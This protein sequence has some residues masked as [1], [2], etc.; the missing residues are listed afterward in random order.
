MKCF[1]YHIEPK[2]PERVFPETRKHFLSALETS[3]KTNLPLKKIKI[4]LRNI[5]F[6]KSH[7]EETLKKRPFRFIK[8]FLQTDNFKKIPGGTL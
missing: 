5:W 7:K 2:K 3:E 4:F 1:F 8:R 6:K